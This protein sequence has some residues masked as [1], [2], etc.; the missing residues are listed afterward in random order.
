[1]MPRGDESEAK[2]VNSDLHKAMQAGMVSFRLNFHNLMFLRW[3]RSSDL[4]LDRAYLISA[5]LVSRE[6]GVFTSVM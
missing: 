2:A 5:F 3:V 6:V 4:L 1:M